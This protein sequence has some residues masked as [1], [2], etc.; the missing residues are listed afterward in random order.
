[1]C[2]ALVG[3]SLTLINYG[4]DEITNPRLQEDN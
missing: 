2:I 4:I 1:V 3:F